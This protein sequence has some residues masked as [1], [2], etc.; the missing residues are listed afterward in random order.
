MTTEVF[1]GEIYIWFGFDL[2]TKRLN[3][4]AFRDDA[5]IP[6][7]GRLYAFSV[8]PIADRFRLSLPECEFPL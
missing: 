6:E 4:L 5:V 8:A 3:S 7:I 1:G 2:W